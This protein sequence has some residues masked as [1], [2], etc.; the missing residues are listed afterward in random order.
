M[1]RTA[2]PALLSLTA[3][4]PGCVTESTRLVDPL[5][6]QASVD[7]ARPSDGSVVGS[8]VYGLHETIP[9]LDLPEPQ[10]PQ[11]PQG[12]D[13]DRREAQLRGQFG[14]S[15]LIGP[16]GRVT[17]QYFLAG[18]L[19][20]TFLKLIAEIAPDKPLEQAVAPPPPGTK[21]GGVESTSILGRM[22]GS[23]E[24]EVT[25]L[26]DFEAI[27]GVAIADD[28]RP[29]QP[30]RVTGAPLPRDEKNATRV[31]LVLVTG[32]EAGL[33]AFEG[34][35]DLFYTSIPQIEITVQVIEYSTADALAFGVSTVDAGTPNLLNLSSNQLVQAYTS[36]FPLR[37]PIV[38][39]NPV[40]DVGL[41]TL[42]G[43]HDS[44]ELNMV[45]EALEANNLADIQSSPKL[46]VRN[47]GMASIRA[48]TQY[49]FPKAKINQFGTA[50]ATDIEFKPVGVRMNIVPVIAGTD[51]VLLQVFADVSLVTG[52]ANTDPV[53]TPVVSNRTATTTVYL[54]ND[55]SLVIGGLKNLTQIE[56]ETKVPLLGD[57]P[58]LGFLFRSTS[59]GREESSVAF[60]ITSRIVTDRGQ[61]VLS[62]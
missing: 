41:F 37:Q 4:V 43:I 3:L 50:P 18:D 45:L 52:F 12:G 40:T 47:G 56:S 10:N 34:A 60:Q 55:H 28:R 20:T 35:F 17:K 59:T 62:Q 16:D 15:I 58:I 32:D 38:G 51:S 36:S 11:D 30:S 29:N 25:Y 33:T 57:I 49:P 61:R 22:L 48:E 24:V 14:P 5:K 19:A 53:V 44:W 1:A 42:G 9:E 23:R 31:A 2:L 27:T 39:A 7:A 21:I 26:P 13:R 6:I 54:R 46:V 8:L